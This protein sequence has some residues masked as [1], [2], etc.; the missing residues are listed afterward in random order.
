MT[1]LKFP[2]PG[3]PGGKHHFENVKVRFPE[4]VSK[5]V[6]DTEFDR[7]IC[8]DCG[9]LDTFVIEGEAPE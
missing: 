6:R 5:A 4:S 3:E 1:F 2:C 8:V 9:I 7:R